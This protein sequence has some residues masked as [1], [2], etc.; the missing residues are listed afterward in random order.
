M[1][2]EELNARLEEQATSMDMLK[3]KVD[4]SMASLGQV[5]QDQV[6][7]AKAVTQPPPPP[8]PPPPPQPPRPP[9]LQLS[10]REGQGLMGARPPGA[11]PNPTSSTTPFVTFSAPTPQVISAPTSPA[12]NSLGSSDVD[13]GESSNRKQ[14]MPK[15]DFPRFDG[16]DVR[17]WL[18]KCQAFFNLYQIPSG[19][20]VQAASMHMTDSAAH[21]YQTFELLN[22]YHDWDI[23]KAS[24][25]GEFEVN[26][27]RNKLMELLSVKQTGSVEEYK[28]TFKHLMYH[29]KL[30]DK[31]LSEPLLVA[32]FILGLKEEIR[33]FVEG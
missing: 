28:R 31:N 7:L 30:Y 24:V 5:Q 2:F 13:C 18:D 22:P 10:A 8:P 33:G 26:T 29:V 1:K 15:L 6:Q 9:Q 16:S 17:I 11:P 32:Q 25:L 21:W 4:L 12:F 3:T 19:F 20:K 14:W 27:H 23:F